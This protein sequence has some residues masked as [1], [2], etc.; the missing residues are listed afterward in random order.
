[1]MAAA[2]A[3]SFLGEEDFCSNS[4]SW[5]LINSAGLLDPDLEDWAEDSSETLVSIILLIGR[6]N[7]W[8]LWEPLRDFMDLLFSIYP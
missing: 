5:V 7:F 1:M 3:Y 2:L 4:G 6:D 8:A